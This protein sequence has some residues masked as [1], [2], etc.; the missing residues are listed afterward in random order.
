M[1]HLGWLFPRGFRATIVTMMGSVRSAIWAAGVGGWLVGAWGGTPLMADAPPLQEAPTPALASEWGVGRWVPDLDIRPESGSRSSLSKLTRDARAVVIAVT[2]T[3]C[4]VSGR[5][6]PT[7]AA[8]EKEYASRGVRFV[9]IN[10]VATDSKT[11]VRQWIRDQG[12]QGPYVRDERGEIAKAL[13]MRSTAEVFVLDAA[14]TVQFRGA[15][16]DQYGLGY[17]KAAPNQRYLV[18]ALEAVLA[19]KG[20]ETACTRVPGCALE[21]AAPVA[22][23]QPVTYHNRISRILQQ[24]CVPCHREGGIAPFALTT[25]AE[26]AAHAGMVRKQ[27]TQGVMPPWFAAPPTHGPSPW[28]NDRSLPAADKADL[29]AWMERGRPEGKAAHAPKVRTYPSEW[30]LGEPDAIVRLPEPVDVA[31]SGV[32]PYVNIEVPTDFDSDRWVQ[33]WEIRPSARDVV[34]HVLVYVLP[35]GKDGKPQKN[36]R[37]D[38]TS[39]YLAAY[40]PGY[41]AVSYPEGWAKFIPA[42]STLHFQLHYTPKGKATRDQSVLGLKFS[43]TP[44]KHEVRVSAIAGAIDIPPGDPDFKVEGQLPVP[45]S[46]RLMSFMPH[47]H[48]RGKAYRYELELPGSAP[49]TLLDV[50]RYDFNWQLLY[51]LSEHIDLPAGSVLKGTARYDNSAGNP[52]NP[53]PTR[54]VQWGEQTDEEMMLGYIEYY[55]PEVPPGT[56]V[57]PRPTAGRRGRFKAFDALDRNHDGRI[58]LDESP[59]PAQFKAADVDGNGEVT[60]EELKTFLQKSNTRAAA[61]SKPSSAA[62]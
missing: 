35:P 4:P 2:S 34:H 21:S 11:A 50:P 38:G 51:R 29:L 13:G 57:D 54:R 61:G 16:D 6:G 39:N 42:G 7:L 47:M 31:A 53:D 32:M 48:V 59:S 17:S 60:R 8:L 22:V 28:L 37:I 19:G 20:V 1:S 56:P 24:S 49:K 3:S 43:K 55:L 12:V 62:P 36:R 44:P 26:V 9:W 10:P 5:Y 27:V 30:Q 58:T 15:V 18:S 52:A 41:Q 46:A 45:E 25:P 40:A 14:R 33:G 23:S